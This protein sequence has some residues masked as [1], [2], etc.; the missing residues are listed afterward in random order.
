MSASRFPIPTEQPPTE[1]GQNLAEVSSGEPRYDYDKDGNS[2]GLLI[3]EASTNHIAGGDKLLK[4]A[5]T[6]KDKMDQLLNKMGLTSKRN[7]NNNNNTENDDVKKDA[8]ND[9]D[10]DDDDDELVI[11]NDDDIDDIM[12]GGDVE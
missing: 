12:E 7:N 4:A 5:D 8:K 6:C 2:L 9:D 10:D 3:E 11:L 1:S